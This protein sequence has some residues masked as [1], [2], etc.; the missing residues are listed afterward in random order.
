M[1]GWADEVII[2]PIAG[3][4]L[5]RDGQPSALHIVG[6]EAPA[7]QRETVT[8]FGGSYDGGRVIEAGERRHSP[9]RW[10]SQQPAAPRLSGAVQQAITLQIGRVIHR[11]VFGKQRRMTDRHQPF[12]EE[13][14][15]VKAGPI[16]VTQTIA[17]CTSDVR[18]S[19]MLIDV[20]MRSSMPA[21]SASKAGSRGINHCIRNEPSMLM[22]KGP[23]P[24]MLRA[25]SIASCSAP[26]PCLTL[27]SKRAPGSVNSMRR[28][29]RRNNGSPRYRSRPESACWQ[30]SP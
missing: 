19:T 26:N 1:F 6:D 30:R 2:A 8:S 20:S 29:C 10:R 24:W 11:P 9:L 23:R 7:R 16:A 15:A 5:T 27:G 28:P 21:C 4:V 3:D 18:K 12:V 22:R 14:F 25:S 13:S 17:A